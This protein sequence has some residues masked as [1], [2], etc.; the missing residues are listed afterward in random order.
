MIGYSV[1]D[2]NG[3]KLIKGDIPAGE[4]IALLSAWDS[5][6]VIDAQLA[7]AMGGDI[8]VGPADNLLRLR[9]ELSLDE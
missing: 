4:L 8:V 5:E 7:L 3:C 9:S 1:S 6:W 2:S